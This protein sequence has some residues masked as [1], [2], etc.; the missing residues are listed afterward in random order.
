MTTMN[1]ARSILLWAACSLL[2]LVG[3][4]KGQAAGDHP[5]G[6]SAGRVREP[7]VAG[8]FYAA[9]AATLR[10]QLEALL[11]DARQEARRA[12]LVAAVVPHAGYVYSG[13]CAASVYTQVESGRYDRVIIL[14]PSH[15]AAFQGVALPAADLAAYRTPLGD[16]PVDQSICRRLAGT[17]G[18]AVVPRVDEREHSLE[19]QLPFLQATA[20][21]FALVPLIC[22][23]LDPADM[24]RL[25]K[26]LAAELNER[27]LLLASSDFTHYGPNYDFVPFTDR[28]RENL[29][30]WLA[31]AAGMIAA[32][33]LDA[34]LRHCREK[35]DTVC[36]QM[37]IVLLLSALRQK[38]SPQGVVLN[39]YLS[40]DRTGDYGNSVSYAAIGFFRQEKESGAVKARTAAAG[41]KPAAPK[42][43]QVK[44]HRSGTWSPGLTP[45]EKKTLFDIARDTL[46]WCVKGGPGKFS[47]EGYALTEKMK[48][49][50]ATFVT[51][52]IQGQLR[53]C[54]GTLEPIEPLY[55]SVHHNAINAAI[56]DPR[57]MPVQPAELEPISIDVSILSPTRDIPSPAEFKIG[58]H[59]IIMA[60]G[61]RRAVYLPEVAPEQ[62]W[63]V[64]ETLS[65][66]SQKAGLPPDAWK[67]GARF[68]VFESVVLAE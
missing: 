20:G 48:Q 37:P 67:A 13:R 33:D 50:T 35:G 27:T 58:Q 55:L 66:L 63:T 43:E 56:R 36:G 17:P 64:E 65:S 6:Q 29:H 52:K 32:L 40:G 18:F 60:K 12:G 38:S 1:H 9:P 34:F 57:F 23:R 26:A 45:A 49:E 11:G 59:G 54:I 51:L 25:G 21:S 30:Q 47:F 39:R 31:A 5:A 61:L 3:C 7:A 44:E 10:Q 2:C 8:G 19:V 22:G 46:A 14:A 24:D 16:I 62:G 41:A 28:P 53:G 15:Y 42:E 68:Q 4:R